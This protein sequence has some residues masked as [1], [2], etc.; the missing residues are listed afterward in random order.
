M[1]ANARNLGAMQTTAD[2]PSK[3][4]APL[5]DPA[6]LRAQCRA[7]RFDGL[8]AGQA[9]GRVQANLM[10][11]P[12]AW[13]YD[14]AVFCQRNPKPCPLLDI[15]DPGDPAPRAIA[16]D[17]DIRS[18]LPRY[19]VFRDGA[20]T[21]ERTDVRDLWRDDMVGFLIGCSYSFEDALARAGL[22]L[23]H[24]EEGVNVPMYRT[25]RACA[26]AG[27]FLGSDGPSRCAR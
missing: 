10:A 22:P 7:G 1:A 25:N 6:E 9:P 5:D 19:R 27:G 4:A 24:H 11:V 26:P 12:K 3:L 20:F 23:R 17:A 13:D 8:T 2:A 18:D 21:E 14:F 15:T 16:P